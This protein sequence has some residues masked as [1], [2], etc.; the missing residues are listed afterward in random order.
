MRN[1]DAILGSFPFLE[2]AFHRHRLAQSLLLVGGGSSA[3]AAARALI[4][5]CLCEGSG[6]ISCTCRSCQVQQVGTHPDLQVVE[7]EPKTIRLEAIQRA[8]ARGAEAPLW[9][10]ASVVWIRQV[11][12]M[13]DE[14]E[15]ALLKSLEEPSEFTQYILSVDRVDRV[16]PTVR[17]R[18]QVV[19]VDDDHPSTERFQPSW[20]SS[21]TRDLSKDLLA[22]GEA[23]RQAY[24]LTADARLISLFGVLCRA[25]AG[26]EQNH[27]QDLVRA[28]VEMAWEAVFGPIR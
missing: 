12:V 1:S 15:N 3:E 19:S 20:L 21:R 6:L 17:S 14:A 2:R 18:C 24:I 7:P 26:L 8:L 28:E 4:R 25:E 27:N 23:V 10:P 22:A 11:S 5:R 13:T 9:S 16:L